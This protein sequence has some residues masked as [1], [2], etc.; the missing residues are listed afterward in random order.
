M[1]FVLLLLNFS[2]FLVLQEFALKHIP[3]EALISA[4]N[5]RCPQRKPPKVV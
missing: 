5:L 1:Y 4:T 3:L 2:I